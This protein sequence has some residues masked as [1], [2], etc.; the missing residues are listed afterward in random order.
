M[1]HLRKALY[2]LAKAL[3]DAADRDPR[4][5]KDI[6][7][8]LVIDGNDYRTRRSPKLTLHQ[9]A[10]AL[11]R[12]DRDK[13]THRSIALSYNVSASTISRLALWTIPLFI[14]AYNRKDAEEGAP[15]WAERFVRVSGGYFV[16]DSEEAL[17]KWKATPVE[18]WPRV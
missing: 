2:A 11:K 7:R 17:Q 6:R 8:A 16:F 1:P 9:T 12:R 15:F 14:P 5:A 4:L 10:E 18:D 13:E 3:A